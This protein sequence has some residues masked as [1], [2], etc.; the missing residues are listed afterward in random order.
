MNEYYFVSEPEKVAPPLPI[1]ALEDRKQV[2]M[3][4]FRVSERLGKIR[5]Y[6]M[7]V[8]P[9]HLTSA[10]LDTLTV[11]EVRVSFLFGISSIVLICFFLSDLIWAVTFGLDYLN[12]RCRY[13]PRSIFNCLVNSRV[14]V[15]VT[16]SLRNGGRSGT[17]WPVYAWSASIWTMTSL[18]SNLGQHY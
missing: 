2:N 13:S 15:L 12:P 16:C 9:W 17:R 11:D 5:Q 4:V 7:M 1:S 18:L 14:S 6:Y 3:K 8:S 10:A